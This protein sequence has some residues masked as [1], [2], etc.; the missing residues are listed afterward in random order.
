MQPTNL[1]R[2]ERE[3]LDLTGAVDRSSLAD[4]L[5]QYVD[6]VVTLLDS[7]ID[8][9]P[10]IEHQGLSYPF[11]LEE[12][13]E[14]A[15]RMEESE[16]LTQ[17]PAAAPAPA[18]ALSKARVA[19][20]VHDDF[21][22]QGARLAEAVLGAGF[23]VFAPQA[24]TTFAWWYEDS[25]ATKL[26]AVVAP[27]EVATVTDEVLAYALAW[28]H[29]RELIML[30][31]NEHAGEVARRLPW[32]GTPVTIRSLA[33]D[34]VE[35]SR[36]NVLEIAAALKERTTKPHVLDD[37]H[38]EWIERLLTDVALDGL[39]A[40][41]R[42]SY[43]SWHH[44]GLQVLRVASTRGGLRLH[45]GVQYSR[46][47]PGHKV[48][49]TTLMAPLTDTG[50]ALAI[51][52]VVGSVAAGASRTSRQTEHRLQSSMGMSPPPSL[53]LTFLARE[54]PGYRGPGRP[55]FI[56]F[57]GCDPA[58]NL[59]IVETKVGHDPKVVLQALDYGIWVL[60]NEQ[61]IRAH[62]PDWPRPA[63]PQTGIRLDFVLATGDQSTA[64]NAY[65]AGQLEALTG[66]IQW[67]VFVVQDLDAHPVVLTQVSAEELWGS[68]VGV[69]S[70]PVRPPRG[71]ALS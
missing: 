5:W 17:Y 11:T 26:V 66:D 47:Q 36:Q 1:I 70:Q 69:A 49:N 51:E 35:M 20:N 59:H 3:L 57:L 52:A 2:N 30:L 8:L 18:L 42:A 43:L 16:V 45:A 61:S 41:A 48:F 50:L 37:S 9:Q 64:V 10:G 28:Q 14:M 7:G 25:E 56:D 60:A 24:M 33:G 40:H 34:T 32:I 15:R 58:G 12:L 29:D 21:A 19:K 53:G 4:V 55:G 54:Y 27:T 46:P 44:R 65:L 68:N 31:S 63:A 62:R 22:P 13:H 71:T 38:I 39:E 67:R 23:R 6:G